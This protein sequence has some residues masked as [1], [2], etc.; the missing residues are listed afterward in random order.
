YI[1]RLPQNSPLF[2][3]TTLFRS[4]LSVLPP[5]FGVGRYSTEVE[6]SA[7]S[8]EWLPSQASFRLRRGTVDEPRYPTLSVDL[9]SPRISDDQARRVRR[10]DIG[11]R[12]EILNADAWTE[13]TG[14]IVTGYTE[15]LDV[16]AHSF[17][18]RLT[19]ES[20]WGVDGVDSL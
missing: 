5:P 1:N 15:E 6:I 20:P 14:Q 4:A 2:P 19:C 9:H 3:Y 8:D 10:L 16:M 17:T 11:D 7:Q 12:V 18:F 13:G